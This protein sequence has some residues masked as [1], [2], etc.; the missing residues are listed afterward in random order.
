MNDHSISFCVTTFNRTDLLYKAVEHALEHPIVTEVLIVDDCSPMNVTSE[1]WN[2]FQDVPKVA[3]K[4]ND[5][6]TGCYRNKMLAISKA[7]NEWAVLADS[8]NTFDKEYFDRI[9]S[10]LVAGVNPKTV[11]QPSFAKPHFDFTKFEGELI[12]SGNAR[13]F[14]EKN[15][16]TFGTMLN[17]MNYFVNRDEYL[18]VWEDRAEPWTADSILHNYNWLK[19][20][21]SIYVTPGLQYGHL[22]HDGSHYKE[23]NRKTGNL[24]NEVIEK[25]RRL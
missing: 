16:D 10:L 5:R 15:Q 11:Y 6:N 21:N 7:S 4:R 25:L 1:I 17:A 24:Y 3:V 2:H 12:T 14:L 22:V 19:A 8:D 18:R 23:H 13:Y 20:G 9:E